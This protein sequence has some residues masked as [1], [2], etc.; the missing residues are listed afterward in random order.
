MVMSQVNLRQP[1]N[2]RLLVKALSLHGPG[3]TQPPLQGRQ[4]PAYRNVENWVLEAIEN[5]PHLSEQ[6]VAAA[7]GLRELR[8]RQHREAREWDGDQIERRSRPPRQRLLRRHL[9]ECLLRRRRWSQIQSIQ[10]RSI[11]SSIR[12]GNRGAPRN[13]KVPVRGA[14]EG[15]VHGVENI[16]SP[17]ADPRLTR[18]GLGA[19][20]PCRR[21]TSPLSSP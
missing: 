3:M 18:L 16:P 7:G 17:C 2:S 1:Q 4:A 14:A 15:Q 12:S 10:G 19:I 5:N 20:F 21:T 11:A 8:R 6:V 13:K 9:G